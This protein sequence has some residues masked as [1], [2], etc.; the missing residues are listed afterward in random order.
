MKLVDM[1]FGHRK[2]AHREEPRELRV[3]RVDHRATLR[4]VDRVLA[5]V[6]ADFEQFEREARGEVVK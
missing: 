1:I 4:R 6:D 5:S 3:A 2:G